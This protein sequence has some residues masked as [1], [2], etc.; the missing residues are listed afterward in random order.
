LLCSCLFD[1]VRLRREDRAGGGMTHGL[2]G[3]VPLRGSVSRR[4]SFDSLVTRE[5]LV[6]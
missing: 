6:P 1:V 2:P 5:R 3:F 4:R